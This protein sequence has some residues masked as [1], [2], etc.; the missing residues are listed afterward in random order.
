MNSEH[1]YSCEIKLP[2]APDLSIRNMA[3]LVLAATRYHCTVRVLFEG[4][5]FDGK[6][7]LAWLSLPLRGW[8]SL[9]VEA[10]GQDAPE[11]LKALSQAA[12]EFF[13]P[14]LELLP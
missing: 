3:R 13:N 14:E 12:E 7:I 4:R 6:S 2:S 8:S 1:V 11:C 5:R 10:S 9:K